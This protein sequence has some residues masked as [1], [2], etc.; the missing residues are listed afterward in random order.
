[1][2][3]KIDLSSITI[4]GQL[5]F[6]KICLLC[7]NR[8]VGVYSIKRVSAT[9]A[10]APAPTGARPPAARHTF[11]TLFG[12]RLCFKNVSLGALCIKISLYVTLFPVTLYTSCLSKTLL[13]LNRERDE[14]AYST[15]YE[16]LTLYGLL[17]VYLYNDVACII[18]A[19][20]LANMTRFGVNST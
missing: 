13:K 18:L 14:I 9:A 15:F 16:H 6:L 4:C 11:Y 2:F 19:K 17:S 10:P 12:Q 1:M 20:N 8:N 3:P 7:R 5:L